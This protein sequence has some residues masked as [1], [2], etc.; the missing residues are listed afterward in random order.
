MTSAELAA[1]TVADS[2]HSKETRAPVLDALE[3][4]PVP[5][6]HE[7]ALAVAPALVDVAGDTQNRQTFDR[8]TL[9]V[10]RLM[11]EAAPD[12]SRVYAAACGGERMVSYMAPRLIAQATQRA[13]ETQGS[14]DGGQP[15]T[16]EDAYSYACLWAWAAPHGVRGW[17]VPQKAAGRNLMQWLD[18][19]RSVL[20][21]AAL[22]RWL[23]RVIFCARLI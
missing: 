16:Y 13:L 5:I 11:A 19:V 8:C 21:V 3:A 9:L 14:A 20:P 2:L 18:I 22:S 23:T 15:L 10:G 1:D 6:P 4:T 7:V 17:T 12:P